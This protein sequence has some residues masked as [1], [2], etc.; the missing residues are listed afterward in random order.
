MGA[1]I[2]KHSRMANAM[3]S[4]LT[5]CFVMLS[6][7]CG[8]KDDL[9]QLESVE[10][11]FTASVGDA[12]FQCGQTIDGLGTKQTSLAFTDLRMYIHDVALI[13]P[14]GTAQP[15]LIEDDGVWQKDGVALL[16]F[17]DGCENGTA[18]INT[19]I[20]GQVLGDSF[21]GIRFSV[22]V[23]VE[24]NSMETVLENRGSPLNQSALFW[25]WRS[26]YKY[27]RLDADSRFF[28]F[29]LGAV[30]C[31]DDFSCNDVNI[32]TFELD[33]FSIS[34][35]VIDLN[36]VTLVEDSDLSTNTEGTAPGCM[37]DPSDPDCEGI[38]ER[39]G[40]GQ[41]SDSAF[42]VKAR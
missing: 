5:A 25:S 9:P 37:G 17:E 32:P 27:V 29:H 12:P 23:P 15:L 34:R 38:F 2:S 8:D 19:A 35:D 24:M 21:T 40:L 30:N 1:A 13:S 6:L 3:L 11:H 10:V 22:G 14:D 33:N 4:T 28:R 41:T 16:D 39:F 7:G 31:D 18:Q 42:S 26:G 36:I 20:R